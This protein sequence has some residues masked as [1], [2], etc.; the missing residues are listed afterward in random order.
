MEL[1]YEQGSTL[2]PAGS[3]GWNLLFFTYMRICICHSATAEGNLFDSNGSLSDLARL[4][5]ALPQ[6]IL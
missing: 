2:H 4:Q 5:P 3:R 6:L 1:L